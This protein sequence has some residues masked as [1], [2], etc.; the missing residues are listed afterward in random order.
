MGE[1]TLQEIMLGLTFLVTAVN[2]INSWRNAKSRSLSG[3]PVIAELGKELIAIRSDL[4]YIRQSA[5]QQTASSTANHEAMNQRI[6]A[7]NNR[8]GDM[9]ERLAKVE[10]AVK[11]LQ[12][13]SK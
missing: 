10:T 2:L 13:K 5:D 11:M 8:I 4:T 7:M 3:E 6:I 1:L 12:E 9:L